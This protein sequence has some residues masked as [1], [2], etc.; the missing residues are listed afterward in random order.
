MESSI[1]LD[2]SLPN[3]ATWFYFSLLLTVAIFFQFGRPF[4]IRQMVGEG[5]NVEVHVQ[6]TS[7]RAG[8]FPKHTEIARTLFFSNSLMI[9]II[10]NGSR[11]GPPLII[12]R[13][14]S[15]TPVQ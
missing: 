15:L 3:A 9:S 4:S 7:V 12:A 10:V 5:K 13:K 2:F 11:S 6:F 8:P 1:F 14:Q